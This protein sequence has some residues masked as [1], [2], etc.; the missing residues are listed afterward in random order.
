MAEKARVTS[1]DALE[2][3]RANLVIYISQARP[4]LE[5]ISSDVV[6]TRVWLE[7]E[8]RLYW[9]NQVKRRTKKL[10]EARQALFS[11]TLGHLNMHH[12][13]EQMAVQ[14]AKRSLD[15]ADDKLRVIR[16]WVREYDALTQPMVKQMEKLHTVLSL[17]LVNALA[18][19]SLALNTLAA[20]AQIKAPAAAEASQPG[21]QKPAE[22]AADGAGGAPQ[23]AATAGG[24]K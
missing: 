9:D 4:A 1:F 24:N 15:E 18:Y 14:K 10:E 5:E 6:R 3:F 2:A 22:G 20:Y 12:S 13:A 19:L 16:K 11:A 8:Q 21:G 7:T 17:D 23:P